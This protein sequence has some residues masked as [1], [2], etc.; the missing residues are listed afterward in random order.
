MNVFSNLSGHMDWRYSNY[1]LFE[2]RLGWN[3]YCPDGSKKWIEERIEQPPII[4]EGTGVPY[5]ENEILH[6]PIVRDLYNVRM[7]SFDQFMEMDFGL[8]IVGNGRSEHPFL[9]LTQ[10]Y[11]PNAVFVREISNLHEKPKKCKNVLLGTKTKMSP[12]INVIHHHPEHPP[13]FKPVPFSGEKIVKSFSNYLRRHKIDSKLWDKA[14]KKLNKFE[15]RMHGA[16]SDDGSIDPHHVHEAM[17]SSMFIWHTK[18]A[19]GCGFTCR[20][21]LACGKPLIVKKQYCATH[22]TLA[23]DYLVDGVNCIDMSV[24]D[25]DETIRILRKWSHPDMYRKKC[26]DV[27]DCFKKHIN[28]EKE[29]QQ[30]KQWIHGLKPG[31]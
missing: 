31:V 16:V 14:K 27:L 29:A 22:K 9:R 30:I 21:A 24:R 19:G 8:I 7:I 28:F 3:I 1:A 11:K 23:S 13:Q 26:Q 18:A 6:I 12:D 10:K 4:G 20:E 5:T 2:K 17:Q 15:F 25:L